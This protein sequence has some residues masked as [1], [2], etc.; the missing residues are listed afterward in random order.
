MGLLKA[1]SIKWKQQCPDS[2]WTIKETI[3]VITSS[4]A[5]ASTDHANGTSDNGI[6]PHDNPL[7][8]NK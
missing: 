3:K 6:S 8:N 2:I 7:R 5:L 1:P 4:V